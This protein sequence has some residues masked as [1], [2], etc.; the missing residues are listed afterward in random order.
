[1]TGDSVSL[2]WVAPPGTVLAY[3]LEAGTIPGATNAANLVI[4]ATPGF[5]ASAVPLGIYYVRVRA[6]DATGESAPS[7]EIV[8]TVGTGCVAAPGRPT[9]L[10]ARVTGSLVELS[11]LAAVAGCPATS[12]V[13]QAGS[14]PG[15]SN[16]ASIEVAGTSFSTPAPSGTYYVRVVARNA[17]GS[18]PPSTELIV[19]L[20]SGTATGQLFVNAN[21]ASV[22]ALSSGRAVV[23]GEVLN[24]S[25]APAL[26]IEVVATFFD[27]ANQLIGTESTFLRGHARRVNATGD[28]DDSALAPGEYGCFYM[29]TSLPFASI[30]RLT[31][32]RSYETHESTPLSSDVVISTAGTVDAGT[33]MR[34]I[35][36]AINRGGANTYFNAP[37]FFTQRSDG[38]AVGCDFT[39][40]SGSSVSL[41]SG[42]ATPT[43]LVAG[44]SGPFDVTTL[45]PATA[46]SIRS[47]VSWFEGVISGPLAQLTESTYRLVSESPNTEDAKRQAIEAW[48]TLQAERRTRARGQ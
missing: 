21:T 41:P 24:Q 35:G 4:G 37:V 33:R 11:W 16:L 30:A 25:S 46:T 2:S 6:I 8:V 13:L 45:A 23:I 1:M 12:Y 22:E 43:G 28:I 31:L 9:S 48:D 27:S 7:N 5:A 3:R 47:W 17:F 39:F 10:S 26:F 14:V 40:V 42:A 38:R 32:N 20:G 15:A 18:S 34:V 36:Q 44:Q 19:A 29:V